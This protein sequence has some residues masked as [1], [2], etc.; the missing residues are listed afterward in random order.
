MSEK[1]DHLPEETVNAEEKQENTDLQRDFAKKMQ[2]IASDLWGSLSGGA[3]VFGTDRAPDETAAAGRNYAKEGKPGDT[4][5]PDGP[6]GEL[7][8]AEKKANSSRAEKKPDIHH[9]WQTADETIDWT[10]ALGH[11]RPTDG[12]TGQRLWD[13]YHRLAP[14][15]LQGNLDAYVEV[16]TTTN[17]LGD[18]TDYVNGMVIRT[19]NADRLECKFECRKEYMGD[20][21]TLYLSALALRIARDLFATLPVSEVYVEGNLDGARKLGVTW[22]RRQLLKKNAAFLEPIAF[23]KECGGMLAE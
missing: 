17:P 13:L 8:K 12:L 5:R 19:P 11:D 21:R 15:V 16:L 18:L 22:Q 14:K 9:L 20:E 4:V 3:A 7:K 1:N 23:L 10:D 2:A 6:A